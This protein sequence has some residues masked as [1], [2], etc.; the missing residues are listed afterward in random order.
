MKLNGITELTGFTYYGM[1]TMYYIHNY[2]FL[3]GST[4]ILN[5]NITQPSK[6]VRGTNIWHVYAVRVVI[7]RFSF[8]MFCSFK[9]CN[10]VTISG[11]GVSLYGYV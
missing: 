1:L 11:K 9:L 4:C 3:I 8:V 7:L 10:T 2:I 5:Y 6:L